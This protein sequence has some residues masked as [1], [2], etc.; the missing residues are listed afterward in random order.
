MESES[1]KKHIN[2]KIAL[3]WVLIIAVN[4]IIASIVII[5]SVSY[6]IKQNEER[7]EEKENNFT[8]A[9]DAMG[10]TAYLNLHTEQVFTDNWASYLN[11][12]TDDHTLS[13][14]ERF[15]RSV[16]TDVRRV[17]VQVV[18]YET[19][20]GFYILPPDRYDPNVDTSIDYNNLKDNVSK[21]FNESRIC[22]KNGSHLHVTR[23]FY[24]PA[25]GEET[26]GFCHSITAI[27]DMIAKDG[28]SKDFVLIRLIKVSEFY[29]KWLPPSFR[30]TKLALIDREGGFIVPFNAYGGTKLSI[31]ENNFFDYLLNQ[32][33]AD[34][35]TINDIREEFDTI[36]SSATPE[37]RFSGKL[38]Y[39]SKDGQEA[40]YSYHRL[41]DDEDW[42]LV[43]YLL[44][45]EI[46]VITLDTT[47]VIIVI[48]G[49]IILMLFDGAYIYVTNLHLKKGMEEI[50]FANEAKT[51]FLSSMSH[52]IRTPMNAI[53]GMT[54]IATKRINDTQQVQECLRQITRASN[55][56]LTLINDVLDISKVES[57]KLTLNPAVFSLAEVM[58]NITS[59]TQ[60]HIKEKQMDFEIHA[61][62]VKHEYIF[63][64][65]LRLNQIL[66]N[67]ISNAIKYTPEKG[68]VLFSIEEKISSKGP[69]I[70]CLVFVV[71]DNGIGISDEFKK[72]M[73]DTFTRDIDSRIN[74][75]Q[76]AGL[77]LA[78]TKQMV[79]M[80]DGTIEVQSKVGVGTKFIVT[81][82]LPIA[83]MMTD[84][85]ILPPLKLLVVDD[86]E[87]F[88]ESAEDTLESLGLEADTVSSGSGAVQMV[89][90][91]H[92]KGNDYQCVIVDWK[93]PD[94][95]G[96]ETIREIRKVVG[97]DVSV[98]II[99]AY[100]WSEIEAEAMAAGANGFI[101]K[102]LFRSTV[103][104]KLNELLNFDDKKSVQKEE[105]KPL[106]GLHLLIAEDN[107]INW[108]IIRVMLEFQ[109]I[110][111]ERAENGQVCIDMLN[112]SAN[113]T[114]DAIL[115][116]IQMPIMNGK[117]ASKIIRSSENE[118]I[119]NI[120]IIAMTA[121][122]FAE[123][124]KACKEAGMNGHVAKP[125]DMKKLIKELS[126]ALK[127]DKK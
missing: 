76:G 111:A 16:N 64:D 22:E 85:L 1:K 15:L 96:I 37:V 24:N 77:G 36:L 78:I 45:D 28:V 110:T 8:N 89:E 98:I 124:I 95:D 73:Y 109:E 30:K 48:V 29:G 7:Y 57:G 5:M 62:N 100:D 10:Q 61:R 99:S 82:D 20:K 86:D 126:D 56:L 75:I 13:D 2:H 123:D 32:T 42:V 91:H 94:M 34:E 107:D 9:L 21:V 112:H 88:L 40:Y 83:E 67:L 114:Y 106:T 46:D 97:D 58:A 44:Q 6:A 127:S 81:L 12:K 120:P 84:D 41:Q 80:M 33:S 25:D 54:T 74:T 27:D 108:E 35:N 26:I 105:E 59:I 90:E 102:P 116:D 117:E 47:L 101:T 43:G 51:R 118:Y 14:V 17:N 4:V 125:L 115:M 31:E 38:R 103:Y 60:P 113:G 93:M 87:L 121:D 71:E 55:H 50:Q 39:D 69:N 11:S 19:L 65:E 119:R 63:A 92:R 79:D 53:I 72:H 68:K 66:I 49:F 3:K 18:D 104:D 52:D 70:V 122:A 23:P